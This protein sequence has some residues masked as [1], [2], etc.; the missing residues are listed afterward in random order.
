MDSQEVEQECWSCE[1]IFKMYSKHTATGYDILYCAHCYAPAQPF[2]L[3]G[4]RLMDGI[5]HPETKTYAAAWRQVSGA[6]DRA[7]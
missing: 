6:I 4:M 1:G 7:F 3:Y 5:Q 2:D